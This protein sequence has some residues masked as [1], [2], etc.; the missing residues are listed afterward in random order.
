M[1][2]ATI[3]VYNNC[4]AILFTAVITSKSLFQLQRKSIAS[5]V[6]TGPKMNIRY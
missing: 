4:T 1:Y 2:S 3:T 5:N 6:D